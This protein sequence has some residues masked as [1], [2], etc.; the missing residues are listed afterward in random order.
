MIALAMA[1]LLGSCSKAS[2][3][4]VSDESVDFA[5]EGGEKTLTVTA[6]GSW[7]IADCPE[8]LKTSVSDDKLTLT[9]PKN[10]TGAVRQ[11]ILTLKGGE[12]VEATVTVTQADK[13]THITVTPGEVTIPKEGGEQT[14]TVDTDGSI[15][16]NATDGIEA[17]LANG[18]LTISA[19]PNPGGT[20]NGVVTLTGDD[21]TT[22]VKVTVEGS[23]CQR[24]GGKGTI[25]CPTCGGKGWHSDGNY[26]GPSA[27]LGCKNCGGSGWFAEGEGNMRKGSG[28]IP[29]PTC[30][31]KGH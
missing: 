8:W 20:I 2:Q 6:D 4:S 13:C 26:D 28:R 14:V 30:G 27:D 10:A 7:D 11:C 1:L 22:E 19:G 31:G 5:K 16:M 3:I 18:K 21:I 17:V 9:V 12:G 15:A 29:C 25:T 23:T 24:C